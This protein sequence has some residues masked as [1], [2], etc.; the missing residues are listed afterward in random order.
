MMQLLPEAFQPRIG[1]ASIEMGDE[2]PA[3]L[4]PDDSHLQPIN[5]A[6]EQQLE[7]MLEAET[8]EKVVLD[9]LRPRVRDQGV[10]HPSVFHPL[11]DEVMQALRMESDAQ[12][13]PTVIQELHAA[14]HL[15]DHLGAVHDL[16]EQYRYALLKG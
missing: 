5:A 3:P 1:L 8:F 2:S 7:A 4:L 14:I 13:D 12:T 15:L 11:R 16:G 10:L 6:V 9:A